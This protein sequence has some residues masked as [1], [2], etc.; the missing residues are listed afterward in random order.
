MNSTLIK[1][2]GGWVVQVTS[3][4]YETQGHQFHYKKDALRIQEVLARY[5]EDLALLYY[6]FNHYFH[7]RP[8]K[9]GS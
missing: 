8:I 4:A 5:P 6:P 2:K 1:V 7:P 9:P 3:L